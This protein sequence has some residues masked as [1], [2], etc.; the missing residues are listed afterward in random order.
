MAVPITNNATTGLLC[1]IFQGNI[2]FVTVKA[3]LETSIVFIP[4]KSPTFPGRLLYFR[5]Q[6]KGSKLLLMVF[7]CSPMAHQLD[8]AELSS[9]MTES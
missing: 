9:N 4:A 5:C 2:G 1:E 7:Q 8:F 6:K 3:V